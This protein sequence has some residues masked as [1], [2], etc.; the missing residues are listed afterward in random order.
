MTEKGAI[1]IV[2]GVLFSTSRY[3]DVC[4]DGITKD[5]RLNEIPFGRAFHVNI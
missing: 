2:Q 4:L 1:R 3:N 5:T